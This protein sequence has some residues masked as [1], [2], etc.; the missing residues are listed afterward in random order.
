[1]H[2]DRQLDRGHVVVLDQCEHGLASGPITVAGGR[3]WVSDYD[4][5]LTPIPV[6]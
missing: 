6:G 3:V 5:R 2:F 4:H 1:V